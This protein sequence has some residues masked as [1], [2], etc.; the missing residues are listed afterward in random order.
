[1]LAVDVATA[2]I[3]C[4]GEPRMG[5]GALLGDLRGHDVMVFVRTAA[6]LCWVSD[7][8]VVQVPRHLVA[9]G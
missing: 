6:L 1:M 4:A 7:S 2:G 8:E 9:R 5:E 3:A